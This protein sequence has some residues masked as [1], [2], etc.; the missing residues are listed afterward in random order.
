MKR[1]ILLAIATVIKFSAFAQVQTVIIN[2]VS[3]Q[4]KLF[5]KGK[6]TVVFESG[7]GE[8]MDSWGSIPERVSKFARVLIYNRPG[9]NGAPASKRE[10][11]TVPVMADRLDR[12]IQYVCTRQDSIILVAHSM[13]GYIVRYEANRHAQNI[14]ALVLIEPSAE[15]V[16]MDMSQKEMERYVKTGDSIFASRPLAARQEWQ[17]YLTNYE[18]M[19]GIST[20]KNIQ[21]YIYSSS[22]LNFYKYQHK[23]MNKNPWSQHFLVEGN[24]WFYL[25]QP[26]MIVDL[27]KQVIEKIS[28]KW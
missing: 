17:H 22:E 1:T 16:Y 25:E 18:F 24:Q 7:M 26:K 2:S 21:V 4:Y 11:A 23:L 28:M 19:R 27:L 13:G 9:I 12:L 14:M 10:L 5:G 8:G 20:Y 6:L 15:E 3:I